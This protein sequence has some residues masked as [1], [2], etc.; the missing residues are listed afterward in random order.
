M[1]PI[2]TLISCMNTLGDKTQRSDSLEFFSSHTWKYG[3]QQMK[4][5]G[6]VGS[7]LSNDG[8]TN[9]YTILILRAQKNVTPGP[10]LWEEPTQFGDH[11]SPKVGWKQTKNMP[12]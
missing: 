6:L 4:N 7:T 12:F 10:K 11:R 3:I 9:D 2:E 1:I 8:K 5:M